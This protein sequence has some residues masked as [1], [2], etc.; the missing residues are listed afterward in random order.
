MGIS[1]EIE[2]LAKLKESGAISEAEFTRMKEA[3]LGGG[4]PPPQE[5]KKKSISI[6]RIVLVLLVLWLSATVCAELGRSSSG[7]SGS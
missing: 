5:P 2:R 6:V 3:A 1:E 4:A 7:S